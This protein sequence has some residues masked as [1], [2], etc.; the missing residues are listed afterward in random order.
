MRVTRRQL[1]QIIK[2]IRHDQERAWQSIE[3]RLGRILQGFNLTDDE[4][5]I[6]F[7]I[8]GSLRLADALEMIEFDEPTIYNKLGPDGLAMVERFALDAGYS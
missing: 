2:E 3:R 1:R 6:V 7:S 5:D 4:V 8:L